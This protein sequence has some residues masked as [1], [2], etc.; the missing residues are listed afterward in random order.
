MEKETSR[1]KELVGVNLEG[2]RLLAGPHRLEFFSADSL[3]LLEP[4]ERGV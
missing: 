3:S 2:V 1:D 4:I